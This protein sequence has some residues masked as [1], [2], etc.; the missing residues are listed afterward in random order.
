MKHIAV[1][2][3]ACAL[4]T[5]A[6]G[7]IVNG[8]FETG[9][10]TGWTIDSHSIYL[11]V[12]SYYNHSGGFAARFGAVSPAYGDQIHQDLSTGGGLYTLS[13]W[14]IDPYES[15]YSRAAFKVMWGDTVLYDADPPTS[16]TQYSFVVQGHNGD[17]LTIAGWNSPA[18]SWIDDISLEPVPEPASLAALGI[19]ALA[20]LRRRRR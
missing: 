16:Y 4:A 5:A 15:G 3:M 11:E 17:R 12:D 6:L 8:G 20:L 1:L 9:D 13:F 14:A 18:G 2:A 7:Q 19:G 10:F